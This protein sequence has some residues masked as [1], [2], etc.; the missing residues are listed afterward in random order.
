MDIVVTFYYL[1]ISHRLAV[2]SGTLCFILTITGYF[3]I[4]NIVIDTN[5]LLIFVYSLGCGLG[6][7]LTIWINKRFCKKWK[8]YN[9]D[10]VDNKTER[11]LKKKNLYILI[12]CK[13]IIIEDG[14]NL[15][16]SFN[17][18]D[19]SSQIY[20]S[21]K[22]VHTWGRRNDISNDCGWIQWR[23]NYSEDS[24]RFFK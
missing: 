2:L 10:L 15:L 12:I 5:W 11:H 16:S 17:V 18:S 14:L 6:C 23:H 20:A 9:I 3:V 8:L 22:H 4:E 21:C 7:S 13:L 19:Y 24:N 1:A